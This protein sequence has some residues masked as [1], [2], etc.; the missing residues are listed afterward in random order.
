MRVAWTRPA[1]LDLDRIQ[2][3]VAAENP[4][5]AARLVGEILDRTESQLAANPMIGRAGRVR[6]T[7]ELVLPGIPYIV[8]YRAT[9]RV[10]IVAVMHAARRWP[11]RFR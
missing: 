6:G 4:A 2:D 11:S 7:R 8:V 9:G 3:F 5:A 1:L 10:E